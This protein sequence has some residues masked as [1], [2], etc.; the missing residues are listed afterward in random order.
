MRSD[1]P[2]DSRA[3]RLRQLSARS[4]PRHEMVLHS[5]GNSATPLPWLALNFTLGA[6]GTSYTANTAFCGDRRI[7][8]VCLQLRVLRCR[9]TGWRGFESHP[10]AP[11]WSPQSSTDWLQGP[12]WRCGRLPARWAVTR[13]F[14]RDPICFN[15]AA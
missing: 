14:Q 9:K 6:K 8:R 2:K 4:V 3:D 15:I 11:T 7:A 1:C 12:R 13:Q 10:V 5:H